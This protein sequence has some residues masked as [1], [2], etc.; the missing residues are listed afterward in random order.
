VRIFPHAGTPIAAGLQVKPGSKNSDFFAY[1]T[2]TLKYQV[3]AILDGV[4]AQSV[5]TKLEKS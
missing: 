5:L 1:F 3:V 4:K 2:R